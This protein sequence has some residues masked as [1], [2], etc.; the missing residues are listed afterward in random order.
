MSD[1]Q[2]IYEDWQARRGGIVRALTQD[3]AKFVDECDPRADNLCLYGN[4]DG[5]WVV[6]LPAQEVPPELPEPVVGINFARD[7]MA[8]DDWL[9]LVAVHS[10][11]WLLSVA[12]YWGSKLTTQEREKLFKLVN[13][14][15]TVR[16]IVTGSKNE[17]GG[18]AIG[19]KRKLAAAPA[20]TSKAAKPNPDARLMRMEDITQ[21]LKGKEAELFWPD[22]DTWYR[23]EM[24]SINTRNKTAKVLYTTG[25][26]EELSLVELLQDNHIALIV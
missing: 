18:K 7:G 26:T 8:R 25:E 3:A 9:T 17:E 24:T 11:V 6:G 4:S 14:H 1:T 2:R 19:K 12:F 23:C 20:P 5:S 15:P 16:E 21:D 22:D 13:K 10:D